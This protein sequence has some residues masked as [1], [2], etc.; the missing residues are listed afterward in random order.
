MHKKKKKINICL[1]ANLFVFFLLTFYGALMDIKLAYETITQIVNHLKYDQ[2][3]LLQL[4]R[5]CRKL[6]TLS[7]PLLYN[8]PQ[9]NKASSFENF[10]LTLTEENGKY[11][12]SVDLHM[13]PNRWNSTK[14]YELVLKITEKTPN[15][16][17]L[18]LD[19]CLSL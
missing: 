15:L 18:N 10:A 9:F 16:Q 7:C 8:F 2:P 19:L 4:N 17:L 12:Q 5:T 6:Y 11:V 3:S 14:T 1:A 13:V